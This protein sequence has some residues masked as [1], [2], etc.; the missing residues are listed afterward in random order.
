[1]SERDPCENP[2]GMLSE[3]VET[4]FVDS[5]D[6]VERRIAADL[7]EAREQAAGDTEDDTVADGGR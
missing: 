6:E 3:D 4:E 7:A 2:R 1:M 5:V